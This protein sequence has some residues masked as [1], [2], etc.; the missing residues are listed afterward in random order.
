MRVLVLGATGMLG[1]KMASRLSAEF[2]VSATVRGASPPLGLE[3]VVGAA[4]VIGGVAAEAPGS[5]AAA[6]EESRPDV[7]VNCVGLVKQRPAAAD[8]RPSITANALLPHVLA[9][10]CEVRG[11]RLIQVS[12]DCVFSGSRGAYREDDV[13]DATDLYGRTKALGE[14]TGPGRLTVRTSIV[15]WQ[16][17]GAT[18]LLEWLAAHRAETIEGYRRAVFSGLSTGALSEVIAALAGG[19]SVAEGLFHVSGERISKYELLRRVVEAMGWP[20]RIR[21]ADEHACDRSLDGTKFEQATGWVAPTWDEMITD[22]AND[23]PA[24]ERW[25]AR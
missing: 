3:E 23:R 19:D 2:E 12:T 22:L 24:Y 25:R 6:F 7:V 21:P 18:G 11:S 14:V 5:V 1:H 10:L 15:G 4:R 20:T 13:C 8:A 16:L 9:D 17:A